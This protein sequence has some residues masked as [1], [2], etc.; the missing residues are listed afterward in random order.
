MVDSSEKSLDKLTNLYQVLSKENC[1]VALIYTR[2]TDGCS[3]TLAVTNTGRATRRLLP[4]DCA[5]GFTRRSWEI[6]PGGAGQDQAGTP[7]A[8]KNA[9][10]E[11][12]VVAVST[13]L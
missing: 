8:L 1:T 3:V 5:R 13:S 7:P 12:T 10:F 4:M 2:R 9:S 11:D 6:S